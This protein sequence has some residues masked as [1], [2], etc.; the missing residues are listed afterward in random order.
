M[1]KKNIQ[2]HVQFRRLKLHNNK[3]KQRKIKK[4]KHLNKNRFI[5]SKPRPRIRHIEMHNIRNFRNER[6]MQLILKKR[7]KYI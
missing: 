7:S 4:E 6:I 5:L 3:H 1:P 2:K